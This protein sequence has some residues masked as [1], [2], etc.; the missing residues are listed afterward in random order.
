MAN[1]HNKK[2]FLRGGNFKAKR[3]SF[4]ALSKTNK[5]K[6]QIAKL[7]KAKEEIRKKKEVDWDKLSKKRVGNSLILNL[8]K[9]RKYSK[10]LIE[11]AKPDTTKL[12]ITFKQAS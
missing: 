3:V 8:A 4:A 5:G 9:F 2:T 11:D 1:E 10:K 7:N 12:H 6:K